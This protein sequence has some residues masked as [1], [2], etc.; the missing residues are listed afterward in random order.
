MGDLYF[1]PDKYVPGH[2]STQESLG[3]CNA[4]IK[5]DLLWSGQ[6]ISSHK[7]KVWLWY[8]MQRMGLTLRPEESP[9][10][11]R[12]AFRHCGKL[13]PCCCEGHLGAQCHGNSWSR[14]ALTNLMGKGQ[15]LV[16]TLS[17]CFTSVLNMFLFPMGE[18]CFSTGV[19][20]QASS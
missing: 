13:T 1:I 3:C 17:L 18:H 2:L 16:D 6:A 20:R 19:W 8:S 11:A 5:D 14:S 9:R 15:I 10:L 4:V 12:K 7:S